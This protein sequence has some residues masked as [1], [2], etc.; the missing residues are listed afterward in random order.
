MSEDF[1]SI[2]AKG[3]AL[4][5]RLGAHVAPAGLYER[6]KA[7][8]FAGRVSCNVAHLEAGSW[9]E[10]VLD[11]EV[12]ASGV[13]DG[14]WL[15]ATFKFYSD[16]ALF[17]TSD[18]C[19]PNFISAEYHAAPLV[20]GQSPATVQALNVRFDQ[21]GHERPFQKAV[22]VDVADGYLNAGDHIVIRLGDRRRGPGTRVQTFVEDQFRFR[23]YVDPLG[24]SRFVAVPGDVVIDI[25]AGAPSQVLLNGPRFVHP[26]QPAPFRV[27]LQDRWGNACRD[28]AGRIRVRGYDSS[29]HLVYCRELD[30][31]EQGWASCALDDLP[32]AAGTL[33][34]VA[35]AP[36]LRDVRTAQV[37]LTVDEALPVARSFYA[38]LHVHAHDTVG[39]N[40]PAYNAAYARDI[41]GIDVLGY[42]ANDFQITDAN[43]KLGVDTVELFNEAGRFVVYPVQ[44]WCGS[45]TAGGDHNV[46]FLGDEPPGFPYNARGEHN[47]TLVWNEDMRG[48]AVELGR[49]PVE[50]LWDAYVGDAEHHLV[51]PHVG[52]RR[53][54]PD[55]HHPELERLVEIASTWGHF[56]WLYRDVIARGY[57]LGVA[58]SGDEHRGRPGGGAPGVQVFGVNGGLTGVLAD[59]LD[60][61]SI[62]RALRARRTWATT[63]EHSAALVRCGDHWQGDAFAQRGPARLDYRLLGRAGW[64]YVAAFDHTGLIWERNL[65]EELGY[66][67]RRVRV[68]WGGARIRDRYR[69]ASWHGRI[70]II[71]GTINTFSSTGFEHVEEAAWRTGTTDIEFRSDTYGDA[72]SVEI[73]IS[74]LANA[75]FIIEGTI[76]SFVKVGDPL[77]G[78]PFAHVPTFHWEFSGAELL[79]RGTARHELGGTE[80]FL[81]LERLTDQALPADLSGS[82]EVAAVNAPFGFR[83]VYFFGRQRDDSKIWSS[84]QFIRFERES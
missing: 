54:I 50:E 9:Q 32:T 51:M 48:N 34:V 44:E 83:P 39:T 40:S 21:K 10:I 33:R 70:R 19:A 16:W 74:N 12:G 43:W 4:R 78:N 14:A 65:H 49:W 11:Y 24:T 55:W 84:A 7:L 22:I 71:N 47:R 72:D 59:S 80:L 79:E 30:L 20:P 27:S 56:D 69:W 41:G 68:R 29:D 67:Q 73:D 77:Q 76:D 37:F 45:S 6:H 52:G 53:Y 2:E 63:G 82:I 8:A 62:G 81:A 66:A 64:E 38:D 75:R 58:A 35:D 61:R 31:P 1:E 36:S 42:T 15:K 18:P 57:Q 17:Q 23:F 28:L 3:V 25:R 60:R 26:S 46:V 13:A 5:A